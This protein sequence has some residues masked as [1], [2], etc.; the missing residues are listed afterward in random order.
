MYKR[1]RIMEGS[2]MYYMYD[3]YGKYNYN[4]C[5]CMVTKKTVDS[6][7]HVMPF[8]PHK[9]ICVPVHKDLNHWVIFVIFP[10]DRQITIIDSL[11]DQEPWHVLMFQNLVK[12]IPEYERS[13]Y[14]PQDKWAWHMHPMVVDKQLNFD[15]CGVCTCMAISYLVHGLDYRTMPTYLFANQARMFVYYTIMG[16]QFDHDNNYNPALEE[17]ISAS[18]I[19]E[20]DAPPIDYR[21]NTDR[22]ERGQPTLT[23]TNPPPLPQVTAADFQFLNEDGEISLSDDVDDDPN[24]EDYTDDTPTKLE[25]T[26]NQEHTITAVLGLTYMANAMATQEEQ[27]LAKE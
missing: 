15:D 1:F 5:R 25:N 20:D 27:I 21:D 7:G 3:Q 9:K 10:A 17:V 18:T 23:G 6:N 12:F 4:G 11:Y 22:H 14:L 16:Y 8:L 26:L 24:D 13:K 19:V 2:F